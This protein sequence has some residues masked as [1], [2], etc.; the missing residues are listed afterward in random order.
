MTTT[1]PTTITEGTPEFAAWKE[2][3]LAQ[4]KA[5]HSEVDFLRLYRAL[6]T[7]DVGLD[8]GSS[9][10]GAYILMVG[11]FQLFETGPYGGFTGFLQHGEGHQSE[12]GVLHCTLWG[13]P[14]AARELR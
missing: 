1:P 12:H 8:Y 11:A 14:A 4:A 3:L 10:H 7:S 2:G 13:R 9:V 6:C 5:I